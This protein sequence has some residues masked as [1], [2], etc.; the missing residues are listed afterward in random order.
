[1]ELPLQ[2]SFRHMH[3]SEEIERLVRE[4]AG[5]LHSFSSQIMSCR[6]VVEPLGRHHQHGNQYDVRITLTVPGEEIAATR[7]PSEDAEHRDIRVSL[8]DAFDAAGRLLQDYEHRKRREVKSLDAMPHGRISK[9]LPEHG[10]GFV[11]TLDG[12]EIYFHRGSV[13]NDGFAR[14]EVGTE[15]AFAEEVGTDGPQASTVKIAGRHGGRT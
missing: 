6:V 12:R 3:P 10:Y 8:R 4:K 15:V 9:L 7:T 5:K 1:M 14:L 13:L 2:V 11:T